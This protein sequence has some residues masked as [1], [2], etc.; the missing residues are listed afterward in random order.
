MAGLFPFPSSIKPFHDWS[1]RIVSCLFC[2][3]QHIVYLFF[4]KERA[5]RRHFRQSIYAKAL[6]AIPCP[7]RCRGR[8]EKIFTFTPGREAIPKGRERKQGERGGRKVSI[9][10]S[11]TPPPPP[12]CRVMVWLEVSLWWI[13]GIGDLFRPRRRAIYAPKTFR[14]TIPC[15]AGKTPSAHSHSA[16][17]QTFR[18]QI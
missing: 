18:R 14:T 9:N 6:E 3:Q 2:S 8:S 10:N 4:G 11:H 13:F 5:A 17:W 1:H 12:Y 16:Y 7:C 15:H